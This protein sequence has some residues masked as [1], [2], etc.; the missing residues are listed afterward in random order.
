MPTQASDERPNVVLIIGDEHN[1]KVLGCAGHPD[2]QTP[3]I[4]RLAAEG[5]MFER[6]ITVCPICTPTRTSIYCG[7]YLLNHGYC[8]LAG[9]HEPDMSWLPHIFT[10]L[11]RA[12]Y[13]TAVTGV[14]HLP[15]GWVEDELDYRRSDY[16]KYLEEIG[17]YYNEVQQRYSDS[18]LPLN[19]TGPGSFS[20]DGGPS[21][22]SYP[23]TNE[24]YTARESI[25]LL[26][27]FGDR[28]FFL[29]VGFQRPHSPYTPAPRFWEMYDEYEI[30]L[31]PNADY[32]MYRTCGRSV[33]AWRASP[34]NGSTSRRHTRRGAVA[35]CAL[36]WAASARLTTRSAWCERP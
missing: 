29:Q 27:E 20:H 11:R 9:E 3:N 19:K 25:A 1:A 17:G 21:P 8:G 32:D 4:D 13:V 31:P 23:D 18:N 30:T 2:V 35:I 24:G 5:V 6:A 7:Q 33:R 36:I 26:D 34:R 12:G 14:L 15:R 10:H 28:P 22:M 16:R